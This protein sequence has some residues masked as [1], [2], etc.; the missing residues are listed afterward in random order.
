MENTSKRIVKTRHITIDSM[1][2]NITENKMKF[3]N[4]CLC[5]SDD[6][7]YRP[8]VIAASY[9]LW[10]LENVLPNKIRV[11]RFNKFLYRNNESLSLSESL[12]NIASNEKD[13]LFIINL[14]RKDMK[15]PSKYKN[16]SSLPNVV[17]L[18]SVN[19]SLSFQK[20]PNYL[21]YLDIGTYACEC[22]LRTSWYNNAYAEMIIKLLEKD[23]L[24]INKIHT[25]LQK[26]FDALDTMVPSLDIPKFKVFLEENYKEELKLVNLGV[27]ELTENI[28][29]SPWFS[30]CAIN[31]LELVSYVKEFKKSNKNTKYPM[32]FLDGTKIATLC[33]NYVTRRELESFVRCVKELGYSEII[34]VADNYIPVG[35]GCNN[36]DLH[37]QAGDHKGHFIT[38]TVYLLNE[39]N[40]L[41]KLREHLE[42][43]RTDL[44]ADVT[45][46]VINYIFLECNPRNDYSFIRYNF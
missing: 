23:E 5:H 38:Y 3:A 39:R 33:S 21:R 35:Y 26:S 14:S 17:F 16:L 28:H 11:S 25:L 29:V 1:L 40:S 4:V 13:T 34:T 31:F 32:L 10:K 43:D 24:E 20:L 36:R 9:V 42:M 45:K 15:S 30:W 2:K 44:N 41:D 8:E 19:G 12:F 7:Y 27:D 46:D 22:L 37:L 6:C 18:S